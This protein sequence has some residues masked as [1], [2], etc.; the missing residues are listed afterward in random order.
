MKSILIISFLFLATCYIY[1][2]TKITIVGAGNVGAT[3][4]NVISANEV[5]NRIVLID[6][7]EGL[8]EGKAMDIMQSAQLDHFDTIVT[9]VTNDYCNC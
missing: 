8:A 3:A 9:G 6:I 2:G 4:A 5:A 7:K 1:R